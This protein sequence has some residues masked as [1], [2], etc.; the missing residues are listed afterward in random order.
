MEDLWLVASLQRH[1][2]RIA[3]ELRVKAVGEP[4]AEY[5][6]G[7]QIHDRHQVDESFPQWDV[8]DVGGP[9]LIHSCDRVDIHPAGIALRWITWNG[10]SGLLLDRP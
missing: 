8:S 3:A 4:P 9:D 2:Q 7:E 1:F 5:V 6:P 10:A